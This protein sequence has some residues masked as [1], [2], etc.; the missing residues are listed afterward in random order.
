MLEISIIKVKSKTEE[1]DKF[2]HGSYGC[3][4]KNNLNKIP[5]QKSVLDSLKNE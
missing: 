2:A 1:I 4:K 5:M 3:K